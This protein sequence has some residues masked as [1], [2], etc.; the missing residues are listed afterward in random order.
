MTPSPAVK[1]YAAFDGVPLFV[2]GDRKTPEDWHFDGAEYLSLKDQG[3]IAPKLAE[4]LPIDHYCRK[5]FAYLAAIRSGTEVIIDTDDDNLPKPNWGFPEFDG[6]FDQLGTQEPFLNI[7]QWFT[8]A[9]VWPRG[10]PLDLIQTQ[11]SK[12]TEQT[13]AKVGVWQGLADGD[14]D[15]DAVYRLTNN[16]PVTFEP[17]APIIL[18]KGV[19]C[20]FNS[21]NT[22]TRRELFALL[23]LPAFVTF[24]F[25]DILRGLVA[26]P[27]MW[28]HGYS[29]GFTEATVF[30]DRNDHDFM[31][32]FASEISMYLQTR[33]VVE[34]VK[35]VVR[36]AE[37][38]ENNL[39][40]AYETLAREGIIEDAELKSLD[41]WLNALAL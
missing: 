3:E 18:P 11:H 39:F 17:R 35:N 8:D 28:V 34:L 37:S 20:P 6:H 30:Q 16:T 33:Q 29:L 27:I 38:I 9:P 32:D 22:A 5:M 10:L 41:A 2:A 14:P 13:P 26:Q 4:A 23:Y 7:Y 24:R 12:A 15:V 31:K 36:P 19:V 1:S 40:A 25:T 21:Q